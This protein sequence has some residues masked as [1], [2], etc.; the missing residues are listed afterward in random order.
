MKEM[1][2]V[3]ISA[4]IEEWNKYTK[5]AI[6]SLRK[7][8]T[9]DYEL[10]VMDNGGNGRGDINT[11]TML[12]YGTAVNMATRLATCERLIILN[13]DIKARGQWQRYVYDSPFCGP[14]LLKVEGVEY[15]EGWFISIE[16]DI[17]HLVNGFNEHFRNS[18]E[19]VDLSWRLSRLGVFPT[20][21][22]V[23]MHHIW[24]A[25]RHAHPGTNKWDHENRK[26]FLERKKEG[27]HHKW[28]K[29]GCEYK[30]V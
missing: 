28:R 13:N 21:I 11:D 20:C 23:P 27:R 29:L 18:W 17:W 15:I 7:H 12:P 2:V 10:I 30:E 19:D 22:T 16:R 1:S 4:G 25:T 6:E 8:A 14:K 3:M 26:Y 5:E 9:D 24:G